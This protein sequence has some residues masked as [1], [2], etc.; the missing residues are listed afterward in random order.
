[1]IKKFGFLEGK[2]RVQRKRRV[3][4]EVD[5]LKFKDVFEYAISELKFVILCTIT[6]LDEGANLSFIYHLSTEDGIVLNIKISVPKENPVIKTIT[7]YFPAADI[8]EREV[9]DLLGAKV[10]G[11]PPGN[12][13]PLMD[14]W[15]KDAYP[16]RK[17]WKQDKTK[18]Q[19]AKNA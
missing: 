7:G 10:E 12:R 14:E 4:A 19:E 1:L 16:L 5:R 8:Y 13:Y 18:E 6:G 3:S 9:M 11:L 17:D 2:V 15:P